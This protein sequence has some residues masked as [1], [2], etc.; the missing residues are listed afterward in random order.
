MIPIPYATGNFRYERGRVMCFILKTERG[1]NFFIFGG[2]KNR[3]GVIDTHVARKRPA[4][5][6]TTGGWFGYGAGRGR[7]ESRGELTNE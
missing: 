2:E 6:G 4:G 1:V 3:L 5:R 7:V